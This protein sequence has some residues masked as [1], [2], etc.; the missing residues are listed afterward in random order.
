MPSRGGQRHHIV[1]NVVVHA[2]LLDGLAHRQQIMSV[3]NLIDRRL[4]RSP[5]QAAAQHRG[6]VLL[7]E[8]AQFEPNREPIQLCLRQ[9]IGAL[10]FDRVV[11]RQNNEGFGQKVCGA[12]DADLAFGHRLQ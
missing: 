3:H 5:I 12:V 2:H 11:G 4:S 10:V 8:V 1:Q 9:W 7:G 6:L